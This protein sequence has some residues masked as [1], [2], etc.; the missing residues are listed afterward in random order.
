IKQGLVKINNKIA[1]LIDEVKTNDK[2]FVKGKAMRKKKQYSVI[3]YHKQKGEIVSKKDDRGRNTIY[4]TLPR[5][6]STWLSVG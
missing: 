5:Q 6:F 2:V 4:D 3:I 1:L